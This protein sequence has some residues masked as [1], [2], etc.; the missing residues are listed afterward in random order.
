[1]SVTAPDWLVKHGGSIREGYD[2]A[3]W[4]VLFGKE[5]QYRLRPGPAGGKFNCAVVQMNN[6]K[7]LD[8]GGLF[9]TV[10][11]AVRGGLEDLRQALGW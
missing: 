9:A 3:S 10:D 5:P 1:M 6:G 2:H 7:R 11:D 8:K 4:V